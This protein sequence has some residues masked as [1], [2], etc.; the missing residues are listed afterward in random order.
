[1]RNFI[2]KKYDKL[3]REA[4]NRSG[5]SVSRTIVQGYQ[6]SPNA[7]NYAH[8]PF[9]IDLKGLNRR[10]RENNIRSTFM[11]TTDQRP[12]YIHNAIFTIGMDA[13]LTR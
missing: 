6:Q 4:L 9:E 8:T 12:D 5:R 10:Q 2:G 13:W 11:G 3:E 1:M 7:E